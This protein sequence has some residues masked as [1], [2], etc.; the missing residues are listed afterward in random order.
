MNGAMKRAMSELRR[1]TFSSTS[2]TAM[3]SRPPFASAKRIGSGSH[4][5]DEWLTQG[6][7]VSAKRSTDDS[8]KS[9]AGATVGFLVG[10]VA[11]FG[12]ALAIMAAYGIAIYTG[13]KPMVD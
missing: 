4:R 9:G 13:L 8:F 6:S 3:A 1:V 5:G 12:C 7:R 10:T 11:R 2:A